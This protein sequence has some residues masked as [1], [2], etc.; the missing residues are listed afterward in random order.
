MAPTNAKKEAR[1]SSRLSKETVQS[2]GVRTG[3]QAGA[4]MHW[5][6]GVKD[7]IIFRSLVQ[8]EVNKFDNSPPQPGPIGRRSSPRR[9]EMSRP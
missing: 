5:V 4:E 9:V 6:P 1:K 3:V 2:L 8:A 7:L